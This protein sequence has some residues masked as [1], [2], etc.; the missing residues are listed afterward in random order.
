[1]FFLNIMRRIR[2]YNIVKV[3]TAVPEKILNLLQMNRIAVWD[4]IYDE[5]Q[6]LC[7]KVVNRDI[8]YANQVVARFGSNIE[9]V[10]RLGFERA[11]S[12]IKA[13]KIFFIF[14]FICIFAVILF[15]QFIWKIEID[16]TREIDAS[17]IR[18]FLY[19]SKIRQSEWKHHID[20]NAVEVSIL[21]NF[22]E[23]S[24]V[25][26]EISGTKL[27][28]TIVERESPIALYDKK[29]SVNLVAL[30]DGIINEMVV[31]NGTPLV[32]SG[33]SVKKGDVL[34]SGVI[35]YSFR[36]VENVSYVHAMGKILTYKNEEIG[37]II[38]NRYKPIDESVC[39]IEKTIYLFGMTITL[40]KNKNS[41]NYMYIEEKNKVLKLGWIELPILC[42][43]KKWYNINDCIMKTDAEISGEVYEMVS[44]RLSDKTSILNLTYSVQPLDFYRINVYSY[45]K[46]AYNLAIEEIIPQ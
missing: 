19:N 8:N 24:D 34:I 31:Y 27:I 42:D 25:S 3:Q 36:D 5:E 45:V 16:G 37:D 14:A 33:D 38:I 30:E 4:I 1:M 41:E 6:Y 35:K 15:S 44:K 32:K 22:S 26:V 29:I 20:T 40:N 9:I 10:K 2:S 39:E 12:I 21:K 18:V 11:L 46:C 13:R 17:D 43:E 7:F 23:I 28:I